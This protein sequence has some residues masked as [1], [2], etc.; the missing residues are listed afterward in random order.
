[1]V[2]KTRIIPPNHIN[3]GNNMPRNSKKGT[4]SGASKRASSMNGSMLQ[5]GTASRKRTGTSKKAS[6]SSLNGFMSK[7]SASSKSKKSSSRGRS[8]KNSSMK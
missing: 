3:E 2:I 7:N 1:M 8:R 6:S 4:Q 5:N